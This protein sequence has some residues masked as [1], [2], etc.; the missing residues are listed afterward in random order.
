MIDL[1]Q[2]ISGQ[3]ISPAT[4][5]IDQP[6]LAQPGFKAVPVLHA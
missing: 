3:I 6:L 2:K 4:E 5:I 1:R